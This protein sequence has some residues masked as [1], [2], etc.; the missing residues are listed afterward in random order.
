[1]PS[2]R[3]IPGGIV[4]RAPG[5]GKGE[6]VPRRSIHGQR[7]GSRGAIHADA[8]NP[9]WSAPMWVLHETL[10]V[11]ALPLAAGILLSLAAALPGREGKRVRREER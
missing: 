10:D 6:A 1:M 5:A 11:P 8:H 2:W 7:K 9:A 3:E 4:R